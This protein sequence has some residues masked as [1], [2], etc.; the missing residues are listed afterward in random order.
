GEG[1]ASNKV[2]LPVVAQVS[3]ARQQS[4]GGTPAIVI[5]ILK[6]FVVTGDFHAIVVVHQIVAELSAI[7]AKPVGET[8]GGRVEQDQRGV[9]R[10]RVDENNFREELGG[11][12]RMRVDYADTGGAF[13]V[14][15]IDDGVNDRVGPER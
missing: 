14:V 2:G 13:L 4:A 9:D 6:A 8:F 1:I 7:V 11:F 3:K 10:A 12:L 15:V 5:F